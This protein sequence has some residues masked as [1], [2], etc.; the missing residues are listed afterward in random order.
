M[1]IRVGDGCGLH[2]DMYLFFLS[3]MMRGNMAPSLVLLFAGFW[4]FAFAGCS[5]RQQAFFVAGYKRGVASGSFG[6]RYTDSGSGTV[7]TWV[8][9]NH[10]FST[11]RRYLLKV[12]PT[13]CSPHLSH[14]S[15]LPIITPYF[16]SPTP[17]RPHPQHTPPPTLAAHTP[18]RPP[19]R[20]PPHP[21]PPPPP[22]SS[23]STTPHTPPRL[24]PPPP[25]HPKH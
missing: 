5:R 23:P 7:K 18:H 24:P 6:C 12:C 16:F 17:S 9:T 8:L 10:L 4:F 19:H 14:L 22:S 1:G 13:E 21:P 25:R 2:A 15:Q 20:H 11:C 3:V